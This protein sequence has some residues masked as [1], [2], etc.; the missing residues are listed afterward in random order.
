M[1]T[2]KIALI[3]STFDILYVCM[4]VQ[5]FVLSSTSLVIDFY[6]QVVSTCQ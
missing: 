2:D 1:Y 3:Q 5:L 6:F 4:Y